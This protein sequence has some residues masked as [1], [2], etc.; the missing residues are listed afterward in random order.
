MNQ[1]RHTPSINRISVLS[2]AILLAYTLSGFISIPSRIFSLQLPGL[3]LQFQIDEKT[4]ISLLT[5]GLTVTGADSLVRGHPEFKGRITIQHWLLPA[6]TAWAIG[7]I[8]FQ[9]PFSILW[10]LIFAI[11]GTALI[12]VLIA[13]YIVV[14]P[15]DSRYFPATI[16]L[17]ALSYALF[18]ILAITIRAI[19]VRTFI[20]IP[21]I[22][23]AAGL[24]SLRTLQLMLNQWPVVHALVVAMIL[25]QMSAALNYVP[26]EPITFALL[27][28]A[29]TYALTIFSRGLIERKKIRQIVLEPL[30]VFGIVW[31]LA[32]VLR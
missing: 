19:E 24:I 13:E 21:T 26:V 3:F 16:G 20:L 1:A 29:P 22:A 30:L 2:S 6:L 18:L 14:D 25:G 17:I 27:L 11:G 23:L 15:N 10:W 8:L 7:L 32:I 4:I 31:G 5:A 9:E 28:L 12:M